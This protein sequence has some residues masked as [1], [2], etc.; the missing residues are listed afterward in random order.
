[1]Y[2]LKVNSDEENAVR[3]REIKELRAKTLEL[4]LEIDA[5]KKLE[6]LTVR[7]ETSF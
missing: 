3:E 6:A 1:M 4:V 7:Q 5:R 2:G